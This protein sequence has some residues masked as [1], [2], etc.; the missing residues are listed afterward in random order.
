MET[1]NCPSKHGLPC[2][3]VIFEILHADMVLSELD[4]SQCYGI[5]EYPNVNRSHQNLH[6]VIVIPL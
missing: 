1:C 2:N 3:S 4:I 6:I 5:I